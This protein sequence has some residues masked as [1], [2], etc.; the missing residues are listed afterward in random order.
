M[1]AEELQRVGLGNLR[2]HD[3]LLALR[4]FQHFLLYGREVA[5]ADHRAFGRHHVIIKTVLYGRADAELDAGIEFLQ[6]FCHQMGG[7]VPKRMLGLR[8]VPLVQH[9]GGILM[10]GTVQFHRLAVHA[11][12]QHVLCQPL[13]NTLCNLQARHASLILAH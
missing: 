11:A 12:G 2:P 1:L 6:G 9:H 10:D 3:G 5:L 13:G 7:S 4:Q 8:V